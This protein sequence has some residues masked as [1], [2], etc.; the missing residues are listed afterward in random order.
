MGKLTFPSAATLT[1][2]VSRR[3]FRWHVDHYDGIRL[4]GWVG[5]KA[6]PRVPSV[7]TLRS[8]ENVLATIIADQPR[9]DVSALGFGPTGFSYTFNSYLEEPISILANNPA[10]GGSWSVIESCLTAP[11]GFGAVDFLHL[12]RVGGWAVACAAREDEQVK[13]SLERDGQKIATCL[14]EIERP[15]VMNSFKLAHP[16]VGFDLRIPLRA[17]AF[18]SAPFTLIGRSSASTFTIADGVKFVDCDPSFERV[19]TFDA[20]TSTWN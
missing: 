6:A 3:K 8:K 12:D 7:V 17:T 9:R 15:D 19:A 4:S 11:A 2:T 1:R 18:S 13:V 20:A 16:R 5:C 14:L 10:V